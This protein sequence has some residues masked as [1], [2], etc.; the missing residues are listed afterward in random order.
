MGRSLK[1]FKWTDSDVENLIQEY[2]RRPMLWDTSLPEYK[3][4]ESIKTIEREEIVKAIG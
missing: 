3:T 1:D 4:K 2:Y